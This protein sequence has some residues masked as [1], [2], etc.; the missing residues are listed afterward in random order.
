ML[1]LKRD[2]DRLSCLPSFADK[3][4]PR[5]NSGKFLVYGFLVFFTCVYKSMLFKYSRILS[6]HIYVCVLL[7]STFPVLDLCMPQQSHPDFSVSF[8]PSYVFLQNLKVY[9]HPSKCPSH[10]DISP[11]ICL[12]ENSA[13]PGDMDYNL[14][15][16]LGF[17][18]IFYLL[19]CI[20]L[21]IL[22]KQKG[23][24]VSSS[25]FQKVFKL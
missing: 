19:I 23:Q 10:S 22:Y 24:F 11:Q 4:G 13:Q 17:L 25:E 6:L 18:A 14:V 1:Q 9:I 21:K 8:L 3:L 2:W 16:A 12:V 15:M 7:S 20:N 5:I